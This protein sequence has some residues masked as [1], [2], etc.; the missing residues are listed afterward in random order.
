M[1]QVPTFDE[2]WELLRRYNQ[3][4]FH[5]RHARIVSGV[6]RYFAALYDAEN[7]EFWAVV[8]LLH[9][10]D[11]ERYPDEHCIKGEELLRAAGVDEGV[12]RGA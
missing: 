2:A 7:T 4:D 12:I 1:A 10:I 3:E 9:D 8:G 5:L 6:M 11:F